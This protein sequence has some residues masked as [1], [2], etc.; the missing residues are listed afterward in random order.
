MEEYPC[1]IL[2]RL[3]AIIYDSFLVFALLMLATLLVVALLRDAINPNNILFQL[4]LLAV[5]WT[6]FAV[7]WRGGQ[8]LGMKSWHIY[9][10]GSTQPLSL[11]ET[12][13]RYLVSILSWAAA[14]LGFLWA[15][16]HP[17]RATWHDLASGTRLV[18][19]PPSKNKPAKSSSSKVD[20]AE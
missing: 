7:C 1:G 9:I 18:V 10:L 17:Q 13:V 5:G 15:A 11:R 19:R 12:A 6:Y 14:G 2:R 8:T 3:A 4:Y 20:E 16:F